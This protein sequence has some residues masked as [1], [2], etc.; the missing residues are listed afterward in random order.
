MSWPCHKWNF[1]KNDIFEQLNISA[2]ILE[3]QDS[4][5]ER[6]EKIDEVG[7]ILIDL[8]IKILSFIAVRRQSKEYLNE[9]ELESY[10]QYVKKAFVPEGY[11]ISFT[12]FFTWHNWI[13]EL[14][15]NGFL[16]TP[17][18]AMFVSG[19]EI[20][21]DLNIFPRNSVCMSIVA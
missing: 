10:V 15:R 3:W 17:D 4:N 7:P 2:V 20:D 12:N 9:G 6:S 18:P 5:A 14:S 13:L 16:A 8:H 21:R 1:R 19:R 11:V